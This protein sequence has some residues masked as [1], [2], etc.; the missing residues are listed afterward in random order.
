M[1]F[2]ARIGKREDWGEIFNP[3][4]DHRRYEIDLRSEERIPM[5]TSSGP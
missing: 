2:Y 3:A 4:P 5:F 1:F